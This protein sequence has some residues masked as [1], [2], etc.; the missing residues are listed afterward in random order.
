MR[1]DS[2]IKLQNKKDTKTK[3]PLQNAK[4]QP[5][6]GLWCWPGQEQ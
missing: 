5:C 6:R 2:G 4:M 1:H 3:R